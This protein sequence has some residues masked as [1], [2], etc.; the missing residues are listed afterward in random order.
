MIDR[1]LVSQLESMSVAERLE[2]IGA[3]WASLSPEQLP[4]T[5]AER[6]LLA[7]RLADLER[8]PADMVP[9]AE[10]LRRLRR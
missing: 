9:G 1:A 8:N 4:V 3:V 7:E 10:A 5:E 2:I 6:A